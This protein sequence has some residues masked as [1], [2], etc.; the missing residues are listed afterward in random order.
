M[1]TP[2]RRFTL[3]TG[4]SSSK[5]IDHALDKFEMFELIL[6]APL[7]GC[8]K[9]LLTSMLWCKTRTIRILLSL[10]MYNTMWD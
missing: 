9:C 10:G 7:T 2:T 4:M 8:Y 5:P 1:P 6:H 3:S